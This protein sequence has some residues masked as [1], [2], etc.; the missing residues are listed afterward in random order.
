[1]FSLDLEVY[2]VGVSVCKALYE[3]IRDCLRRERGSVSNS[4]QL[5]MAL[6]NK[7]HVLNFS[8]ALCP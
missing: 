1:M 2:P 5:Q 7:F 8:N 4:L 6:Q 3:Q